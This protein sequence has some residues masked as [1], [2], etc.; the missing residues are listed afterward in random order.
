MRVIVV[1]GGVVGLCCAFSLSRGGAEVTIVERDRCGHGCSLGNTG[2][3]CPGLSAPLPA[4]GVM[5]VALRGML[6]PGS[7]I[8]IRPLF[9][10][11]FLHWSLLFWRSCTPDRYRTGLE[12]TV[13][14]NR[15]TFDL[16]D[17]LHAAGVQFELHRTGMVVA[18][19][20]E[21]GIDEYAT[22]L[23]FAQEACFDAPVEL[24]YRA[25]L[26]CLDVAVCDCVVGV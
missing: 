7:P 14:L 2:W 13:A 12:A 17:E 11:R 20:S 6:R 4:P 21:A 10:P 1:G 19:L 5:S 8:L 26:W 9:G 18:A 22:M 23:R 3:I 15:R 25:G 16:F 24:L